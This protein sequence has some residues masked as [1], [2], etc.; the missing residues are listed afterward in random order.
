MIHY[1]DQIR[2]HPAFLKSA[3]SAIDIYIRIADDPSL[4]VEK[5]SPEEEAERKKAAKKAQKAEQ[6][7]R[8]AAAASGEKKDEAPAPDADPRGEALLKT[9]TPIDD[10]LKL[11]APLQA[12]HKDKAET[13]LAGY[14][15]H[16]RKQQYLIALRDLVTAAKIDP[17]APG[18]LPAIKSFYKAFEAADLAT[19][20]QAAINKIL[21]TL[22]TPTVESYVSK[23]PAHIL[24]AARAQKITGASAAD[25]RATLT[26]LAEHGSPA[27]PTM[28]EA[29][30]FLSRWDASEAATLGQELQKRLPLA[31]DFATEEE[32]AKRQRTPPAKQEGKADV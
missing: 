2:T 30:A 22:P 18:L 32:K 27:I 21:P 11:W 17:E 8:K 1:E 25:A 13:W 26:R 19:P 5:V 16:L 31:F 7:A 6:K 23:T 29:F 20:V 24:A 12:N 4:T 3:L 10:A 15:L 9:E 28:H 14:E